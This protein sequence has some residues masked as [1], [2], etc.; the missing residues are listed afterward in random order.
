MINIDVPNNDIEYLEI[1]SYLSIPKR[2]GIYYIYN[3]QYELMYLGK[4]NNLKQRV[5]QHFRG[6]EGTS[7]IKHNFNF[8]SCVYVDCPVD[9]EI[10]ETYQIN[11][12][13][14]PLNWEKIYTYQSEK[15]SPKYN[16]LEQQRR[17]KF[18]AEFDKSLE[19]FKL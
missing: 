17:A 7:Q 4:A 16:P 9:R 13:K 18:D 8:V 3:S 15:F 5:G 2:P 10:Y 6:C 14:P 11:K 19:G 1:T 12:L